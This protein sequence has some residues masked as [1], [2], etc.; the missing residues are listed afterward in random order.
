MSGLQ[1]RELKKQI[2]PKGGGIMK[3]TGFFLNSIHLSIEN[4]EFFSILGPSGCGKTT[5][6]KVI[7]GILEPDQGSIYWNDNDVTA[8]PP[9]TRGFGMVFQ[10][11]LLFP[12]LNVQ[13]N[14]MFGLKMKKVRKGLRFRKAQD[15][16][17]AVGLEG[18]ET[19]Y[20]SG[21]SGG[22]QQRVALARAIVMEPAVLLMDEPFSALDRETR[23]EMRQLLKHIHRTYNMI[24]LFVTH[25]QEEAFQLSDRI[26]IMENGRV[27]EEGAPKD[28]IKRPQHIEVARFLGAKNILYGQM[29]KGTFTS[30]Y[31][32]LSLPTLYTEHNERGWLILKPEAIRIVHSNQNPTIHGEVVRQSLPPDYHYIQIKIGSLIFY[33]F[34]TPDL[35]LV[36]GD[37]VGLDV[38]AKHLHFIKEMDSIE[39]KSAF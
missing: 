21:L 39:S 32:S 4:G 11:P 15:V 16:L 9:E 17:K 26:A 1:V 13:E 19:R 7:A 20:P 30:E 14:V 28:L 27:L 3:A 6:L 23:N 24:I 5:L 10:E 8:I 12:H 36:E 35:E 22:Q 29:E 25:D 18:F 33:V 34:H 38:D 37:R 31:L 2:K